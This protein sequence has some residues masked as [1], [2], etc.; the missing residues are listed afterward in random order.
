MAPN[1]TPLALVGTGSGTETA[2]ETPT[3]NGGA[4]GATREQKRT[5]RLKKI[6]PTGIAIGELSGDRKKPF[7]VRTG[8]GKVRPSTFFAFERDRN[9]HAEKLAEAVKKDGVSVLSFDEGEVRDWLEFKKSTGATLQQVQTLW[10]RFRHLVQS[11]TILTKVAAARYITLRFQEGLKEKSD[12]YYHI[13]KQLL[14]C[15]VGKFGEVPLGDITTDQVRDFLHTLTDADTG[16]PLS[17]TTKRHYRI[18]WNTFFERAVSE[19]WIAKNP[20]A[21]VIP[22]E[23]NKSKK[24]VL[25]IREAFDLLKAN[26]DQ[27]VTPRLVLE[28]WG[29]MRCSSVGRMKKADLDFESRGINMDGELHKSGDD[30][31]RQGHPAVVWDWLARATDETWA[32]CERMYEERKGQAFIRANVVN[33]GNTLRHSCISYMLAATKNFQLVGYLAQHSAVKITQGYEGK[34]K[35][36][37]AAL[38]LM[39]T[40]ENVA[41]TWEDFLAKATHE[42]N[43]RGLRSNPPTNPGAGYRTTPAPDQEGDA[44]GA[45]S[46]SGS[47]IALPFESQSDSLRESAAGA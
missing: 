37:D 15:F 18:C 47:V 16:E 34:A 6:L 9:D 25:P 3:E 19:E 31:Y 44:R 17:S 26:L 28:M 5:A 32:L 14:K 46:G 38:W 2:L 39:L 45:R 13:R 8:T 43:Q 35:E 7:Y 11:K 23:R 41:L 4:T 27:P 22:P 29:F 10:F 24:K 20:C 40:P 33:R 1:G 42:R 30:K 21:N 12:T 36:A